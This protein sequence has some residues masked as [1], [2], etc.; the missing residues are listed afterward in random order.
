M[1]TVLYG[2]PQ[3]PARRTL[4][5]AASRVLQLLKQTELPLLLP[6]SLPGTDIQLESDYAFKTNI[7]QAAISFQ[8][9]GQVGCATWQGIVQWPSGC[10]VWTSCCCANTCSARTN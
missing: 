8:T 10:I 2:R 3:K 1:R 7:Y 9:D 5:V 6:L 4:E